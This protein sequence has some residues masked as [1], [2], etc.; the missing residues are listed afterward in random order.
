VT[1]AVVKTGLAIKDATQIVIETGESI[2]DVTRTAQ[3]STKALE[4]LSLM[5]CLQLVLVKLLAQLKNL[6]V[7]KHTL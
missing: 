7:G 3:K 6:V 2:R 4:E 1:Q 5:Q